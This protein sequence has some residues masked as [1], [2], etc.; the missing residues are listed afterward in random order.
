MRSEKL[1]IGFNVRM[2]EN[3]CLD[4]CSTASCSIDV[5]LGS[6]VPRTVVTAATMRWESLST[7]ECCNSC[8]NE[9]S[10]P[11]YCGML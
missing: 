2:G 11:K 10:V 8:N 4:C 1:R 6:C 9:V 5:S 7:A 3:Q